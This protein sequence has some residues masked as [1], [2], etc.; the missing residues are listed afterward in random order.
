MTI[1]VTVNGQPRRLAAAAPVSEM[2]ALVTDLPSGVAVAVNGEVVSRSSWAATL[3]A[4]GDH[5]EIITA[6]QGG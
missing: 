1:E 5:V 6:V 4:D 3:V 2:V